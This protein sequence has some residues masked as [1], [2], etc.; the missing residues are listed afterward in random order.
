MNRG[1]QTSIARLDRRLGIF[2]RSSQTS[3]DATKASC[4]FGVA[5]LFASQNRQTATFVPDYQS[6]VSRLSERAGE[7]PDECGTRNGVEVVMSEE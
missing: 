2:R 7:G 3:C 4:L 6:G 1:K 5:A